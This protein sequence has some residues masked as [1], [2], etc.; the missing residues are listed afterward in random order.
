MTGS[1]AKAIRVGVALAGLALLAACGDSESTDKRGYTKSPL[2]SPGIIIRPEKPSVMNSLGT[3]IMPTL[4]V[5][6]P[7][8][9]STP[10]RKS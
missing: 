6:P 5:I 9:D 8:K 3:P 4:E 1:M 10:A 7:P 2:E